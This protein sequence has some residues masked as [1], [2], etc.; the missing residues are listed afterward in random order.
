MNENNKLVLIGLDGA[1]FRVLRPLVKAGAMPILARFLEEG[2][3]GT[4]LSTHPPV[5]CPAW[6]TMFTGANP[7]KHGIFSFTC[8]DGGQD[9]PHTASLLDVRVP[10]LW[11][12]LSNGGCRV[13]VMN[14]PITFPAHPV[15]GF[16]VSGF[17]A[18]DGLSEVMWPREEYT[19][20]VRDL[21][22]FVVNWPVLSQRATTASEKALVVE[23]ANAWLRTRSRMFEYFLNRH[24]VDFCFLVFE[25]PDKVQHA[26]YPLLDSMNDMF[27]LKKPSR[28]LSLLLDGYR[29]VDAAIGKLV[30]QFSENANYIIVSDHGFGPANRIVYI[31]HLLELHG[32]FSARRIKALTAKA[33]SLARLP[34]CLQNR[35]GLAQDE[36]WHRINTWQSPLTNFSRTKAF[37]G[38]QYEH[39]VYVNLLGRCPH[40]IVQKGSEYEV[41]RNKV[42]EVLKQ[43][44]D[45]KTGSNIFEAIWT[46]EEIYSGEYLQDAPDVIFEL[47]PGYV[48]SAGIGLSLGLDSGFLRDARNSDA[49]GYHRPEG[50]FIG[51][52]PSFRATRDIKATL[53]DVAPTVLALMGIAPL[54]EMDGRVITEA[55]QP[56]LLSGS[57]KSI[58]RPGSRIERPMNSVY[59]QNDEMEIARRLAD[60]GYL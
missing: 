51:Y 18:P 7:G 43:T 36:P 54:S 58:D 56:K 24:D 38:H 3:S 17:P 31:N 60:L 14:V 59:S 44:K 41:V 49:K 8:R 21:P 30:G 37:G 22:E 9:K 40:G 10:T 39:A 23:S 45:P 28:V 48:I 26:F 29:Q 32:L 27:A 46:P 47:A 5:T 53:L 33:A 55:I 25:Y 4:L 15:N 50:V 35:L 1:T 6:P 34:L 11:E 57:F 12:L 19:K 20:I 52:G 42:I 2:A 13:G 16:M